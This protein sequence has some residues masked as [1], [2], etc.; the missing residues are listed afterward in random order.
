MKFSVTLAEFGE[1]WL[2]KVSSD[3]YARTIPGML[4]FIFLKRSLIV[5]LEFV[6][7]FF[8]CFLSL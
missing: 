2:V 6:L 5:G 7:F 1:N 3:G 4:P 8:S